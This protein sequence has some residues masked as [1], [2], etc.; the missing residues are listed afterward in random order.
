MRCTAVT[1]LTKVDIV[2]TLPYG[3]LY[4][5]HHGSSNIASHNDTKRERQL[6]TFKWSVKAR[7]VNYYLMIPEDGD[8]S[9]Q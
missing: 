4:H 5:H 9:V 8:V 2:T 1:L 6:M 7:S 3:T